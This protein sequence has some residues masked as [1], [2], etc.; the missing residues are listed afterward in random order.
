MRIVTLDPSS[1][2]IIAYLKGT[3]AIVGVSEDS[4]NP[5]EVKEKIKVTRKTTNIT[6]DLPSEE[7]DRI[8]REHIKNMKPLHEADWNLIY[9]LYPDLVVGQNI[10][11]TCSL[12]SVTPMNLITSRRLT[13]K[14]R[15]IRMASFG[16]NTFMGIVDEARKLAKLTDSLERVDSL[17]EKFDNARQEILNIAKGK[18]VILI[19]WIKPIHIMGKWVT[20][21][22]DIMG[23]R[24]IVRPGGK[25]G[26]FEWD[27][28]REFN[29]DYLL[30][31]PCSFPVERTMKEIWKLTS[32]PGWDDINA[33]RTKNVY[34]L[35]PIY[36]RPTQNILTFVGVLRDLFLTGEVDKKYGIKLY[37]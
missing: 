4:D 13:G 11:E 16:P 31:S 33:V 29:P 3:N 9:A 1:T 24:S 25:G 19:E 37:D 28:I 6:N 21:I 35:E 32:L 15:T 14:L 12:P 18:K 30:I 10:C 8:V 5:P 17:K 7:I 20:D 27:V 22:L 23:S 34:V 36:A 2:E 26:I